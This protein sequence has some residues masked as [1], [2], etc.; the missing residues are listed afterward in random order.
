MA[1]IPS[2]STSNAAPA[3]QAPD[4]SAGSSRQEPKE[5]DA[6]NKPP[7]NA[8]DTIDYSTK[9]EALEALGEL[10]G[11]KD[12]ADSKARARSNTRKA[13]IGGLFMAAVL[14]VS[15]AYIEASGQGQSFREALDQAKLV[16]ML[17]MVG[18]M[19]LYLLFGTLAFVLET[20][21]ARKAPVGFLD[22]VSVEAAGTFFGNLT[23][24]MAGSVPGQIWRLLEAGLDF[25]SA[26]AVQI[27]RFLLFQAAEI[28]L[29]GGLLLC[30]W[31]YFFSHYGA[32][33]WINVAIFGFKLIQAMA[34]LVMCLRP[35]WVAKLGER[36]CGWIKR[37]DLFGMG[38][39]ADVWS[40]AISNQV[41]QF[42]TTF[43]AAVRHKWVMLGML[44]VSVL[45]Q[46]CIFCSP[47]FVLQALNIQV[48]FWL[49]ACA[50]SMVQLLASAIPLPGGTGGIEASFATFFAPWMGSTA[51][52]GYI[53][54]RLVTYYLY[55][56]L[57]GAAT[58]VRTP[59][60]AP[61]LRQRLRRLVKR[62][63]D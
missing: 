10:T 47:W 15:L 20:L 52:A 37:R 53:L 55:T 8:F 7:L 18:V 43:K 33:V 27:N 19:G 23:P 25:G 24:M 26:T 1:S 34:L 50:G 22:L 41:T 63:D 45:Q 16:W 59:D 6:A 29:A 51:A 5:A 36:L 39:K 44:V 30:N 48:D 21:I 28:L 32:V 12:A 11:G 17:A 40:K 35:Q 38:I 4:A 42:S 49:V 13:V 58:L 14:I 31:P 60:S 9:G 57:C 61:T 54:W 46:F 62:L 56:A 2:R 3:A